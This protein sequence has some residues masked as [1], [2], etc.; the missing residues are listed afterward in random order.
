MSTQE[1]ARVPTRAEHLARERKCQH[2]AAY[3]VGQLIRTVRDQDQN[4]WKHAAKCA[5]VNFPSEES[6]ARILEILKSLRPVT[7]AGWGG[8]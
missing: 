8:M 5:D 7:L 1:I 3:F 2:M 4:Q 6:Q